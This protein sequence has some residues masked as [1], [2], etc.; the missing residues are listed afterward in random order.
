M[1]KAAH[2]RTAIAFLYIAQLQSDVILEAKPR[3][4]LQTRQRIRPTSGTIIALAT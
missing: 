1:G 3:L 2:V 4:G